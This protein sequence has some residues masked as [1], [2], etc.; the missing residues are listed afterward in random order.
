MSSVKTVLVAAVASLTLGVSGLAGAANAVSDDVT[1]L[2]SDGPVMT[3]MGEMRSWVF[4]GHDLTVGLGQEGVGGGI[5]YAPSEG[6]DPGY[7]AALSAA[8][9]GVTVDY[10]DARAGTPSV[11]LMS[12]YDCVYVWVNFA[13]ANNVLYGDNLA[14]FNDAGGDVVLGAFCTFT[15]GNFLS[16]TIMTAG[17]S[18]VVSPLGNNHFSNSSYIGDGTTCIYGGVTSLSCTFRDFLVTQGS[19]VVDGTYADGEICHAYRSAGSGG[20]VVYSNGSGA[21]ALGC[22]G[23]WAQAVGNAC[24]CGLGGPGAWTDEGF[25]LAGVSGDPSLVGAGSLAPGSPNSLTLSNAAAS[26]VSAILANTT[27]S[28]QAFKGGT[29]VPTS[30]LLFNIAVNTDGGGGWSIPFHGPFVPSGTVFYVQA[31]IQDAAAPVGV[32][33]SNGVKGTTP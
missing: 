6:D 27:S 28:L 24:T 31:A 23:S 13:P 17:Y 14:T 21:S 22:A 15:T 2:G 30:P 12:N 33:L 10:F 20:D 1:I 3:N 26:A 5:L 18:P 9:G 7:R 4:E 32:A 29:L 25:A 16:G 8:A 11:A 19:G